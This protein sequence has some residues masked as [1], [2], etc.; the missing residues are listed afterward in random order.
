MDDNQDKFYEAVAEGVRRAV[1]QIATSATDMP[2]ADFFDAIRKG[3]ED[4]GSNIVDI[5]RNGNG[6]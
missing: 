5:E 6:T 3:M 2:C 1:W 4:A